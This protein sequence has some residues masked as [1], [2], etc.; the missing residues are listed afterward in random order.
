MKI[1]LLEQK[2]AV[3]QNDKSVIF[4]CQ[5]HSENKRLVFMFYV[6]SKKETGVPESSFGGFGNTWVT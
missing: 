6:Y 2:L 4:T 5:I 1:I 3:N